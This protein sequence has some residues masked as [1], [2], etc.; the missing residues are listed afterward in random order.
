MFD[1][2]DRHNDKTNL[3]RLGHVV[4]E[5]C[6]VAGGASCDHHHALEPPPHRVQVGVFFC[7]IVD[8]DD[9]DILN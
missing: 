2:K 1:K 4:R 9:K 5:G 6:D 7:R 8:I 3:K